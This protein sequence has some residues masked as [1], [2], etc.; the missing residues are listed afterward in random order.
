MLDRLADLTASPRGIARVGAA[1]CVAVTV[2]FALVY[3][4]RAVDRLGGTA[5]RNAALSF[6][7]RDVAGGNSV[8][9]DQLLAYEARALIPERARYRIVAGPRLQ[10]AKPLTYFAPGW[11]TYFLMPRVPV[12]DADWVVCLGCELP[13]AAYET[14]WHDDLGGSILR[15]KT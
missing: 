15:R 4:V 8:L 10:G 5:S 14:L 9:P 13:G 6:A 12:D 11:L 7:D 2:A 1:V 3:L